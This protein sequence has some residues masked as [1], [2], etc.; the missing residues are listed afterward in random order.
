M[1]KIKKQKHIAFEDKLDELV[2]DDDL[3]QI[4]TQFFELLIEA[5]IKQRNGEKDA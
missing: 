4:L 3:L 1:M 2:F 5:D